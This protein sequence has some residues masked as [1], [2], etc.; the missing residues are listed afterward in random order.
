MA[1]FI[2][3]AAIY[4]LWDAA[5]APLGALTENPQDAIATVVAALAD[6]ID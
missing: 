2:K 5:V 4:K 6:A 3:L 1:N